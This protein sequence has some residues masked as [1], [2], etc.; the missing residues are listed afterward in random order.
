MN[1]HESKG[2]ESLIL[3]KDTDK[4]SCY[5]IIISDTRS[6]AEDEKDEEEEN[7]FLQRILR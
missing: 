7:I 5:C 4:R 1:Q 2:S 3:F 6:A